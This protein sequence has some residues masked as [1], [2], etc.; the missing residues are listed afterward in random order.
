MQIFLYIIGILWGIY[1]LILLIVPK[2]ARNLGMSLTQA[3]PFPV[4]GIISL[5]IAVLFWYSTA[6]T[7]SPALV[8]ALALLCALKGLFK[9]FAPKADMQKVLTLWQGLSDRSL[10]I[11]GILSLVI[12]VY[13]FIR[14]A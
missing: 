14:I 13:L 4:W 12:V 3:M 10:R 2:T 7:K 8:K 11:A 6:A 5:V 1:S 9:I